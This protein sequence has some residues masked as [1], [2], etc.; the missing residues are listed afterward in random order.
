MLLIFWMHAATRRLGYPANSSDL[1]AV[2]GAPT[3]TFSLLRRRPVRR[4][5]LTPGP[6]PAGDSG[7]SY[8]AGQRYYCILC[9]SSSPSPPPSLTG[10]QG[11][12]ARSVTA[13][14]V[15]C[16][17]ALPPAR[18]SSVTVAS[19]RLTG[20]RCRA[21]ALPLTVP[22][23]G[24]ATM[25]WLCRCALL[26]RL[27]ASIMHRAVGQGRPQCRGTSVDAL[28]P[29]RFPLVSLPARQASTCLV[30]FDS[31]DCLSLR[32][33]WFLP[34]IADP[35]DLQPCAGEAITSTVLLHGRRADDGCARVMWNILLSVKLVIAKQCTAT[36]SQN[37]ISYKSQNIEWL[38]R[39][40][41]YA[42]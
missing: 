21:A 31:S 41:L 42:I 28:H 13:R 15:N 34:P 3:S 18:L 16:V 27:S 2:A 8:E 4:L 30:S 20:P 29:A 33:L 39:S 11:R 17:G 25:C 7:S 12:A 5:Q 37:A 9:A 24:P 6:D 38:G 19:L 1:A 23:H 36:I 26:A 22:R 14:G 40:V 35:F 10:L 32:H